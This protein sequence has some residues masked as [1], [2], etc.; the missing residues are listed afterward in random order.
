MTSQKKENVVGFTVQ[1]KGTVPAAV[2]AVTAEL[3]KRGFGVLSNIDVKKTIK[4]KIGEDIEDYVILDVCNPRH[5]KKALDAHKE[6]G[7]AL[8]CKIT[9]YKDHG[10]SW[11]SLY[12]PTEAIRALGLS[13]LEPLAREVEGELSQALL[14]VS[15]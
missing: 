4:E 14:A 8:P 11:I 2:E 1:T 6:V 5:A 15:K 13:D 9:V 10:S 7:L 12:K 3:K